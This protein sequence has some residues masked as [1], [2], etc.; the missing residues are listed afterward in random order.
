M[1]FIINNN[2]IKL[3]DK[4]DKKGPVIKKRG[5]KQKQKEGKL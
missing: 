1:H 5:N 4:S 2:E 3:I